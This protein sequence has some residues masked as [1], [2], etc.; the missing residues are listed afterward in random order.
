MLFPGQMILIMFRTLIRRE[1]NIACLTVPGITWGLSGAA[2][3]LLI[4]IF[5]SGLKR[6]ENSRLIGSS[7][8]AMSSGRAQWCTTVG[9]EY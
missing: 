1:H 7:G 6:N 8:M 4:M 2:G 3:R 5:D 9:T